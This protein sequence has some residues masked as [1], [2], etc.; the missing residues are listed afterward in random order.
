MRLNKRQ[1]SLLVCGIC[2]STCLLEAYGTPAPSPSPSPTS[3]TPSKPGTTLEPIRP[4]A[5][6]PPPS[7]LPQLKVKPKPVVPFENQPRESLYTFPGVVTWHEGEWIGRENLYNISREIGIDVEI[8]QPPGIT[9]PL[10]AGAI[11]AEVMSMLQ[12]GGIVPGS[13]FHVGSSPLP[14]IHVLLM[15]QPIDKGYAALCSFRFFEETRM[16]RI[17]LERGLTWQVIT[18]E[19]QEILVAPPESLQAQ[20]L[21]ILSDIVTAFVGRFKAD[22]SGV[23]PKGYIKK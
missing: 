7:A 12:R 11:K 14:F 16:D 8:V 1:L 3:S 20:V 6:P 5:P 9:I 10:T 22:G 23:G 18:W 21:K 19:K 2:F 15:I 13:I 4:P 17:N